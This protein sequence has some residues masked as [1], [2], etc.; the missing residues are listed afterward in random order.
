MATA[1]AAVPHDTAVTAACASGGGALVCSLLEKRCTTIAIDNAS[2]DEVAEADR[3]LVQNV[4]YAI[5]ACKHPESL[6]VSWGVT[7]TPT[8]Y[9]VS[10]LLPPADFDVTLVDLELIQS[11]SPLRISSVAVVSSQDK[12][13]LVIKILNHMQRV[14][15]TQAD[16]LFTQKRRRQWL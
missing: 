7:C 8:H 10:G 15:I 9:V 1:G 6:C 3:V 4:I 2:L 14:Q 16:V 12:T 11:I 13:K 5:L